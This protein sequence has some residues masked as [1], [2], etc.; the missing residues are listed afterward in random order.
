M[1]VEKIT[2]HLERSLKRLISQY[3]DSPNIES[4]LRVYGP[5]IQQLENMFSDIFT[6]TIFLQSEGEQLDRIGLILNQPRQGLSD[7]DYKTVLIGKIAEYNSEGTPEDLINIY[8]ILTDA[9]QIQ[10][11]EIYPAN[12][13]LHATNAN[14][15]GTL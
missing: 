12:F 13:R 2:D 10:Y 8:S 15:I 9:Q 5:E 7:L 14:P 1:T 6:K 3:K 11:E 4:I